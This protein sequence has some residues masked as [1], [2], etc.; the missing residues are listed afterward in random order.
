MV[1][2]CKIN[3]KYSGEGWR[4]RWGGGFLRLELEVEAG[5]EPAEDQSEVSIVTCRP[6][7]AHLSSLIW[8]LGKNLVGAGVVEAPGGSSGALVVVNTRWASRPARSPAFSIG[9]NRRL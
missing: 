3:I 5:G 9:C 1:G 7:T 2:Y 8:P 6:I 4:C